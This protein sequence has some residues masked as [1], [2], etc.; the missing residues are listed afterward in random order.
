VS[1]TQKAVE[2]LARDELVG[3]DR[4]RAWIAEPFLAEWIR[5][6]VQ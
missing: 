2:A 3:R 6:N 4:G 1:S 5:A